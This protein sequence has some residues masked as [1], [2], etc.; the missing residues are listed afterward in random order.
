MTLALGLAMTVVEEQFTGNNDDDVGFVG[1]W[2]SVLETS[3]VS[4]RVLLCPLIGVFV[5]GVHL[6]L[7]VLLDAYVV[8]DKLG[9]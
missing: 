4:F 2:S 9:H 6:M 8:R 1:S 5:D 3:Y 7:M